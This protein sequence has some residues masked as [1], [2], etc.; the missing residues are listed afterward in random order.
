MSKSVDVLVAGGGTAGSVAAIASARLGLKTMVVERLNCLGGTTTAG[1]VTPLMGNSIQGQPLNRGLNA[2]LKERLSA[3]GGGK[4]DYFDPELLKSVLDELATDSGVTVWTSSTITG[5]DVKDGKI[6]AAI[7]N[8][9]CKIRA[10]IFIDC[11][12][13]A[14]L[15]YLAGAPCVEGHEKTGLHQPMTLRFILGNVQL[16]KLRAFLREDPTSYEE[17]INFASGIMTQLVER[18]VAEGILSSQENIQF[19]SLPG[20]KHELAMNC[21]RLVGFDPLSEESLGQAVRYGRKRIRELIKFFRHYIPGCQEACVS[22]TASLVGIR[23]GR[24]IVGR[25]TL[26][27]DDYL[28]QRKFNDGVVQNNYQIDIHPNEHGGEATLVSLP[29]DSFHE[30]PFGSLLPQGIDN[31]LV[32]G[33]CIST[34]FACQAAIRIIPNCR[35]LGEVAAQAASL[36]IKTGRPLPDLGIALRQELIESRLLLASAPN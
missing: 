2:E 36:A 15:A 18:A 25:Y 6:E 11:T 12:G 17:G 29:A 7:V 13:D 3:L 5:V 33:R 34:D 14:Q 21:P 35:N 32:A 4:D 16:E 23:E 9:E 20:R 24:R 28:N 10:K 26:T 8:N 1:L 31:L 30:I 19:F 27:K 22:Q